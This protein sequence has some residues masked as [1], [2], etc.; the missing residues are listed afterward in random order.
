MRYHKSV[1]EGGKD[2]GD[3]KDELTRT[4]LGTEVDDFLNFD[5]AGFLQTN[6]RTR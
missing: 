1:V 2:T 5:L 6:K 3:T 4:D